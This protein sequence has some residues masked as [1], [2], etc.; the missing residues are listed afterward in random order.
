MQS[1]TNFFGGPRILGHQPALPVHRIQY[2]VGD[3]KVNITVSNVKSANI[4]STFL[5]T[6]FSH[7]EYDG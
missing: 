3:N 1:R 6:M 4:S 2:G 5:G 7:A